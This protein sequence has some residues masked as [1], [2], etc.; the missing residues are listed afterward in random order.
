VAGG[1]TLYFRYTG[2]IISLHHHL[3]IRR[4]AFSNALAYRYSHNRASRYASDEMLR[5]QLHEGA[6]REVTV[7]INGCTTAAVLRHA[8]ARGLEPN[9]SLP[10]SDGGDSAGKSVGRS[11][12]QLR[13][14]QCGQVFGFPVEDHTA[15]MNIVIDP[16]QVAA[17]DLPAGNQ[18]SQRVYQ[19]AING[20]F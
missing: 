14:G 3:R 18:I 13:H 12:S 4:S 6:S 9:G 15:Q 2:L 11:L 16:D 20:S 17:P 7:P 1:F 19:R 5:W 8:P 10:V